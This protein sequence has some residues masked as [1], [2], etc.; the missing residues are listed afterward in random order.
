MRTLALSLL[1]LVD[2]GYREM[3][4]VADRVDVIEL[5]HFYDNNGRLVFDQVIF[6]D[7][8]PPLPEQDGPGC[9]VVVAWQLS[10]EKRPLRP[11]HNWQL[12]KYVLIYHDGTVLRRITSTSFRETWTQ[13]DPERANRDVLSP[14]ARRGLS[15][16]KNSK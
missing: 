15:T 5:N 1:L 10:G 4:V 13:V 6:W 3:M 16:W 14:Y 2:A 9:F 8:A 7:W 11:S 12:G